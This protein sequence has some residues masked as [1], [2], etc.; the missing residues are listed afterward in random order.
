MPGAIQG[1]HLVIPDI[2]RA[3]AEL[4]GRGIDVSELYHFEE[5]AQVAGPDP[6]RTN[7]A[8]FCSF[9]DPDVNG[10]LRQEVARSRD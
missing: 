9:D 7:Y 4:T 3:R 10:W 5:M 2:E 1:I 8:T 6:G